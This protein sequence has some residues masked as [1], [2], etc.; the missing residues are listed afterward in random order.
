MSSAIEWHSIAPC[1]HRNM[2]RFF[3]YVW[4]AISEFCQTIGEK[5]V[6]ATWVEP[7]KMSGN[8]YLMFKTIC[9]CYNMRSMVILAD[10]LPGH[11]RTISF[12]PFRGLHTPL[13]CARIVLVPLLGV[14]NR[15][16]VWILR[17]MRRC[18]RELV[19]CANHILLR[20][21]LL[22]KIRV[23]PPKQV[24]RKRYTPARSD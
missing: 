24:L 1:Q 22:G 20:C 9:L 3:R 13:H 2:R 19:D 16:A 12:L 21:L 6:E 18:I 14:A 5:K 17:C 10:P 15:I 11:E 7:P 23:I 4:V 8:I